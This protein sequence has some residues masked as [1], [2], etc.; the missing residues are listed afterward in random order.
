MTF[1]FN[2]LQPV[3]VKLPQRLGWVTG[4]VEYASGTRCYQVAHL[5]ACGD[6]TRRWYAEYEL[7]EVPPGDLSPMPG[8]PYP[9]LVINPPPPGDGEGP[10]G[11]PTGP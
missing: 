9:D 6:Y 7:A 11:E 10:G 1:K 8:I 5:S 2:Q 4:R 3:Q